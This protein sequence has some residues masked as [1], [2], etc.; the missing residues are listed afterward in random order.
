M[1]HLFILLALMVSLNAQAADKQRVSHTTVMDANCEVIHR[2][3]LRI[4]CKNDSEAFLANWKTQSVP[5]L[6]TISSI[7]SNSTQEKIEVIFDIDHTGIA[8]NIKINAP[9]PETDVKR[10]LSQLTPLKFNLIRGNKFKIKVRS[11]KVKG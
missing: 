4:G 7:L 11:E 2:S 6:K 8:K 1:K 9:I 10:I 5:L 3:D